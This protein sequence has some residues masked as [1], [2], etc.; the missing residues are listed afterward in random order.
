MR[1]RADGHGDTFQFVRLFRRSDQAVGVPTLLDEQPSTEVGAVGV[2]VVAVGEAATYAG[3]VA[4]LGG[5]TS[6]DFEV[7]TGDEPLD[8]LVARCLGQLVVVVDHGESFGD[9]Y[10]EQFLVA[11]ERYPGAV[12]RCGAQVGDLELGASGGFDLM[13]L[14]TQNST[15]PSTIAYPRLVLTELG[16]RFDPADPDRGCYSLLVEAATLVGVA[17]TGVVAVSV[18]SGWLSENTASGGEHAAQVR[19]RVD[20]LPWLMPAGGAERVAVLAQH[21]RQLEARIEQL[22]AQA[23]SLAADNRWLHA[24]LGVTPVR[25]LRRL[26]RRGVSAE[27]QR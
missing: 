22:E 9:R 21:R 8:A 13:A 16:L 7:V 5:Q 18:P 26:L 2:S 10:I 23:E 25:L 27:P 12:L 14:L 11:A 15:P 20:R 6:D 3:L 17:S 24:E 1:G 4:A 19:R